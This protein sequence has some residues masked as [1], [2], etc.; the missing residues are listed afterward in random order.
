MFIGEMLS[1][2][3]VPEGRQFL[4]PAV[5]EGII[6]PTSYPCSSVDAQYPTNP[7]SPP[8]ELP[9]LAYVDS[10]LFQYTS[11]PVPQVSTYPFLINP[12]PSPQN[13]PLNGYPYTNLKQ[14]GG[15]F[16]T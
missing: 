5:T 1:P 11:T 16:L 4:Y 15:K 2:V 6:N 8:Q 7:C 12:I 14:I 9:N 13:Y 3:Q 10:N